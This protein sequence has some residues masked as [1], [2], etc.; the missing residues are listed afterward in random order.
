VSPTPAQPAEAIKWRIQS[1]AA[2]G[3]RSFQQTERFA[4]TVTEYSNGRLVVEAYT[5]GA[6]LPVRQEHEGLMKGAVEAIHAPDG[7]AEAY[8]KSAGLFSQYVAGPTGI[9]LMLWDRAGGGRELAQKMV[10]DVPTVFVGPLT[11]HPAEVWCESTK[12]LNTLNDIKGLKIRVGGGPLPEIF[13]RLG[14]SPVVLSGAEVY[15]SAKRG[16]IDAFEY[17]TPSV[18]WGMGFQEVADYLYLS[19]V[20]APADRQSVWVHEDAWNELSPD[21]QKIVVGVTE[22]L[23]PLFFGETIVLDYEALQNFQDYGTKVLQVPKEIDDKLK[24][25]ASG[26]YDELAEYTVIFNCKGQSSGA[27]PRPEHSLRGGDKIVYRSQ[28]MKAIIRL[29]DTISE[30]TGKTVLWLSVALVLVLTYETTARYVF[31]SPTQWAYETSFMI[32]A[33]LAVLGWSYTHRHRGHIRVDVF[34]T[35]LSLRGQAIVDVISSFV[36]LFPLLAVLIYTAYSNMMFSWKLHEKLTESSFLPPAGPIKTV[37]LLGICL[38]ALQ[39][40]AQFIRDVHVLIR[41]KAYD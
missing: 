39:C 20:R 24:E 7:W 6:I 32:G 3:D 25:V 2:A 22:E 40:V 16:V 19:P 33:T 4:K 10:Q 12:A 35:H 11:V 15:E 29:I 36:F 30:Y 34:Y 8:F 21:L 38:F 13:T 1:F 31:N 17:I 26:Y 37:L 23:V 28:F 41:N 14:A 18:N 5:A 9:Q 27:R